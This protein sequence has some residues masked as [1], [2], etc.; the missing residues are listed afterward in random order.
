ME[1]L[2]KERGWRGWTSEAGAKWAMNNPVPGGRAYRGVGEDERRRREGG[3]EVA[4]PGDPPL[5]LLY[6]VFLRITT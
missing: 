3:W 6:L 2:G 5:T 4:G 1:G